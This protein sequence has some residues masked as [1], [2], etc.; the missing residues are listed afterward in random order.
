[1]KLKTILTGIGWDYKITHLYFGYSYC[2]ES[3]YNGSYSQV[4]GQ[5][6]LAIKDDDFVELNPAENIIIIWHKNTGSVID[7][8]S[9]S[10]IDFKQIKEN[11]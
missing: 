9:V 7:F 4:G 1:M 5:D 8:D 6:C 10:R 11:Q 2:K 3:N